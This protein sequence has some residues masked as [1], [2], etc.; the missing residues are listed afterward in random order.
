MDIN[1]S[2]RLGKRLKMIR[3]ASGMKQKTLSSAL[4]IPASLLSMY[5]N[6]KRELPLTF[7]EKFSIFFHIPLSQLFNL[8][9]EESTR[10][11]EAT[12]ILNEIKIYLLLLEKESLEYQ[13]NVK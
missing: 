2:A 1:I 8:M 7:I 5:E 13:N 10:N 11:D 6:G 12:S 3:V 9:E 4:N